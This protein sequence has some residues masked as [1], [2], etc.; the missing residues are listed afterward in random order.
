MALG[1]LGRPRYMVQQYQDVIAI[2]REYGKP[3][4]FVTFTCNP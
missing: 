3:D 2:V 1:F 4:M